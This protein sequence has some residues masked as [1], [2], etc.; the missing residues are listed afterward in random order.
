MRTLVWVAKVGG[1]L[2][3]QISEARSRVLPLLTSPPMIALPTRPSARLPGWV[4][5]DYNAENTRGSKHA[6]R[7]WR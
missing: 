4:G 5:G 2:R 3:D 6:C 7:G 1:M